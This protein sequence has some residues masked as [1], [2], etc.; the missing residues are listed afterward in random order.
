MDLELTGKTAV[1]TGG[2]RGIGKAIARELAREGVDVAIVARSA[3][4][5]QATAAELAQATGRK[6]TPIMAD[7]GDD[8]SV[9][10][11]IEQAVG[12]LGRLDILVNCA[13][14]PGGQ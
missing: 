2:S 14:A 9:K 4:A 13:A 11:M 8:A 1:V 6:I 7:T 10:K 12:E 3:E 5:L